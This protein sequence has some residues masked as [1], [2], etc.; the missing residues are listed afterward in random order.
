MI[1]SDDKTDGKKSSI[2]DF[3]TTPLVK[4]DSKTLQYSGLGIQLVVVIL[5]FL[6]IGIWLDGKFN[7]KVIF[8]LSLTLIG[9]AAGFY[10]FFL[11]IKKLSHT[12]KK[13][14]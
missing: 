2:K 8:T 7:T 14:N 10:N 3:L 11:T 12:E 4:T 9:F 1:E 13:S 6:W 5:V